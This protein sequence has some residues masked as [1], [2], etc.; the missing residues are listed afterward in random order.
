M[1]TITSKRTTTIDPRFETDE[2]KIPYWI[3]FNISTQKTYITSQKNNFLN[4]THKDIGEK[5]LFNS[6]EEQLYFDRNNS[7]K[8]NNTNIINNNVTLFVDADVTQQV[9][10]TTLI[11]VSIIG[12][13][14]F[15]IIIGVIFKLYKVTRRYSEISMI[16]LLDL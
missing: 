15:A 3:N 16:E 8:I 11:L 12:V 14:I 4:N 10:K 5:N 1:K 7:I 2:V 13:F 6:T 9:S